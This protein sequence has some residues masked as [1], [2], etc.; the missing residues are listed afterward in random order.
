MSHVAKKNCWINIVVYKTM[1]NFPI[2]EGVFAIETFFKTR[3]IE[4]NFYLK[5]YTTSR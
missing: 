2:N 1:A 5:C 3:I 4:V